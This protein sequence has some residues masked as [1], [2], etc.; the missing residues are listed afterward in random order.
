MIVDGA[1]LLMKESV[2]K[3][4]FQIREEHW[5]IADVIGKG[6]HIRTSSCLGEGH[7]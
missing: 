4:D 3:Y 1:L 6:K 5:I 7:T 2:A